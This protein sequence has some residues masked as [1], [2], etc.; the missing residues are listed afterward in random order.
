MAGFGGNSGVPKKYVDD[1][2]AQSTAKV[3][4]LNTMV[5]TG[6]T[7]ALPNF[8]SL[9][10]A[11]IIVI[12]ARRW[13]HAASV[14]IRKGIVTSDVAGGIILRNATTDDI[15]DVIKLS[16]S[17]AGVVTVDSAVNSFFPEVY[18]IVAQ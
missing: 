1:A 6:D 14:C 5:S 8:S 3:H 12:T 15:N 16:F 10:S 17:T 11:D 4:D 9:K 18:Y 13:G 2:I 7:F